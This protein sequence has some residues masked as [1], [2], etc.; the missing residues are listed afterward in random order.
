LFIP[1]LSGKL[2]SGFG[3][4]FLVPETSTG[5]MHILEHMGDP[6]DEQITELFWNEW[7]WE[8]IF[9]YMGV[10]CLE[11]PHRQHRQKKP[12]LREIIINAELFTG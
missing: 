8:F 3:H 4:A 9:L 5:W 6:W 11:L 1:S 10:G 7:H 12:T 2:S